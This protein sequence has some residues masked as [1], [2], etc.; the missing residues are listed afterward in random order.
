MSFSGDVCVLTQPLFSLCGVIAGTTL[1]FPS[2][3]RG[4]LQARL[5]AA[6][7]GTDV[8]AKKRSSLG[9]SSLAH[10]L[11][12]EPMADIKMMR[13]KKKA[14]KVNK[15][16]AGATPPPQRKRAESGGHCRGCST[17]LYIDELVVQVGRFQDGENFFHPQ[18]FMCSECGELLVDLR[19][20]IDVGWEERDKAG[21][22]KRLFC[23]RHWSDNRR[24]RCLA[25]DETIH[26]AKHVFE[27]GSSWHFR[28]FCCYICDANLTEQM[29]YVPREN[30]PLCTQCYSEHVADKCVVC[31]KGIN[32]APGHGGKV[33]IENRHWHVSRM[34][35]PEA[36]DNTMWHHSSYSIASRFADDR[37]EGSGTRVCQR[38]LHRLAC[39]VAS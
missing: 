8:D 21:A 37:G 26:Q 15:E 23:G 16:A 29:T 7:G 11:G 24:P 2:L 17:P 1:L 34:R 4:W 28:H 9:Q 39:A 18:C 31:D 6:D 3:C 33:S 30:K 12:T 5:G 19:C 10:M 20:F 13:K 36:Y 35:V 38:A 32:P 27:M 25:C 22:E 14:G